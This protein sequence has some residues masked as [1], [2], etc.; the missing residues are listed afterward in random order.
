MGRFCQAIC[1]GVLI[2]LAA[3][4]DDDATTPDASA[5]DVT[6]AVSWDEELAPVSPRHIGH[7]A[8]WSRGGL[9]LWDEQARAVKA[10]VAALARALHPG[11]LRWPGGTRAMKYHFDETIG[12]PAARLAQCDT[13]T[14]TLDP[15]SWGMDEALGFA[16]EIGAEVTL[17]SPWHDGTP[18]RAAAMVAYA[19]AEISNATVIGVDANG[20]DWGTAGEWAARRVANGHAAPYDVPFLEVGNEQYLTVPPGSKV[21][22]T[23]RPFTHTERVENGVY[24]V[25]TARDVATQVALTAQAVK[26]ID[27]DILVGAPALSDVI[28]T[29]Q[30]DPATAISP[31]DA[32]HATNEAWNP[33]LV[34]LAGEHFDF[35]VV[36]TYSVGMD[37]T[38]VRLADELR[39]TVERLRTLSDHPVAVTEFGTLFDSGTL[40]NALIS[41]D[42]VRV[43]V[44]ERLVMNLRHLLIEDVPS[45]LFATSAAILGLEHRLMPGY[46]AMALLATA[47]REQAVPAGGPEAEVKVLATRT[48]ARDALGIALV[49]RRYEGQTM[50][51]RIPLPAGAWRGRLS[52]LAGASLTAA[53]S[54]VTLETTTV[55]ASNSIDVTLPLHALVVLDLSGA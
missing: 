35:W 25:S 29:P 22:G 14:G 4:A 34:A 9:G 32:Q 24:V 28:G 38:R 5:I 13:F 42:F 33:T 52:V 50:R 23:D 10:D 54:A 41:A 27:P 2:A 16:E 15:T 18:Q 45:G 40:M 31:V 51:V 6:L 36:H 46:H 55:E 11:V 44:E 20:R 3:C 21:C 43:A 37:E 7:N 19:N 30:Q 53:D 26:A 8:V 12:P 1:A 49:D 48:A 17:V 39:H 47:L